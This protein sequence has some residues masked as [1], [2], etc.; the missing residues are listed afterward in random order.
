MVLAMIAVYGDQMM[1]V[2]ERDGAGRLGHGN[3]GF[4]HGSRGGGRGGVHHI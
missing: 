1:A 4:G 3:G 2:A